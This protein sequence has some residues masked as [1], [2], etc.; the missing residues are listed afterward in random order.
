MRLPAFEIH[1]LHGK[2]T[3]SLY[4]LVPTL[5]LFSALFVTK[6][7]LILILFGLLI[8][9]NHL[10]HCKDETFSC[11]NYTPREKNKGQVLALIPAPRFSV[12]WSRL[13]IPVYNFLNRV[14]RIYSQ[15]SVF[16][17]FTHWPG[18][19]AEKAIRNCIS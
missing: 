12:L 17:L 13:H 10:L 7:T 9:F 2:L 18:S 14:F 15:F 5:H 8:L 11:R 6:T 4:F 16:V 1:D 3:N 19:E